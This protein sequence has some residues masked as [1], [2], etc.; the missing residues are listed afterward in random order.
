MKKKD[1]KKSA[2][3]NFEKITLLI[4]TLSLISN[5]IMILLMI[6]GV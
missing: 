6:G 4:M 2:M 5:I 3:T 1:N